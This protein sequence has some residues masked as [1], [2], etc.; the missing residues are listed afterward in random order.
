MAGRVL[1]TVRLRPK[2]PFSGDPLLLQLQRYGPI[3][4]NDIKR[5]AGLHKAMLSAE[6]EAGR[7]IINSL[8]LPLHANMSSEQVNQ[9]A[10]PLAFNFW[11]RSARKAG[12]N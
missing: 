7:Y 10:R 3:G 9:M 6:A 2:T 1:D 5:D 11:L 8:L 4:V 12:Y